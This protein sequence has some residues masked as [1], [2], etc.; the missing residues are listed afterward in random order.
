MCVQTNID[1]I[2]HTPPP[3][4]FFLLLLLSPMKDRKEHARLQAA[5]HPHRHPHS[6]EDAQASLAAAL[7]DA[8]DAVADATASAALGV[9]DLASSIEARNAANLQQREERKR[10]HTGRSMKVA[11]DAVIAGE[12]KRKGERKGERRV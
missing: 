8:H 11:G 1:Q 7:A 10:Q 12:K 9:S 4:V 3:S 6:H 5:I 2:S